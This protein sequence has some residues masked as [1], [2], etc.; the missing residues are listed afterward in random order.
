MDSAMD[1]ARRQDG[2]AETESTRR[3]LESAAISVVAEIYQ[4]ELTV[5]AKDDGPLTKE[6]RL[7]DGTIVSDGRACTMARGIARRAWSNSM[8]QF[9]D[10]ICSL[11]ERSAVALGALQPDLPD[12]VTV[13]TKNK[14]R[15]MKDTAVN[16]ICRTADY[17]A[18]R[19]G[20][21][22][23][24]L[25]DVDTKGMPARVRGKIEAVGGMMAAIISVMPE[26]DVC[27][28]VVR[29]STSTGIYRDDTEE[30]FP[31]SEGLHIYLLVA[32]G[33]DT[34]RFLKVLHARMWLSGY[35]WMVVGKAG[36][37]LERSLIDRMVGGAERLV[38]EAPPR[39]LAPLAQ[40]QSRRIPE[41]REGSPL[42]TRAACPDLSDAE[43]SELSAILHGERRLNGPAAA[44]AREAFIQD[45]AQ[46]LAD[47]S[48]LDLNNARRVIEQQCDG[49]LAPHVVL[50]WD[51]DEFA[52]CTVG[53]ILADPDR[54]I[55][56]TMADPIQGADYGACRATVL[57][58]PSGEIFLHSFAHGETFYRLEHDEA[59]AEI[60]RLSRLTDMAY[61]QQRK[62]AAQTLGISVARLDGVV[63]AERIRRRRAAEAVD[64]NRPPPSGDETTRWPH[65]ITV[66]KDGLYASGGKAGPVW[67]CAPIKVL[68]Y[69]RDSS[70]EA[71][72]LFLAWQ[73]ADGQPHTWALPK[74]LLVTQPGELEAA[75]MDRGLHIDINPD[76]RAMLRDALGG[77]QTSGRVTLISQPGWH[78]PG[79]GDSAF[80]L[81]NGEMIGK[82]TEQLILKSMAENAT[83]KAAIKGTL[84]DW[85]TEIAGRAFGNPVAMFAISAAFA[86]PLLD[87][88]DE[89]SGGFHFFGRSKI[90]KTLLL[91]VAV[92]VW[93]LPRKN[94]LLRDWRSTANAM[95]GAAE[96]CND[97]LLPL[98]E[99]H[100]ADPKDVVNVV[101]SLA[102][103]SGKGRLSR[104]AVSRPR[105]VWRNIVLSTGELDV[106]TMVAKAGQKLPAGA[107]V[108][109]PSIHLDDREVWPCLHDAPTAVA[110]MAELQGALGREY[111]TPIR[112]FLARLAEERNEPKSDIED[113]VAAMRDRFYDLLPP[114]CDPQVRDVARRCALIAAG[115]ELAIAWGILPWERGCAMSGAQIVLGWWLN[116]RGG[117]AASEVTRH[118]EII[119]AFLLEFGASRFVA[120]KKDASTG[121][122]VECSPERV[123]NS[124]AGYR[125]ITG[126]GDEYL[127]APDAWNAL[128]ATQGADPQDV[129]KTLRASGHLDVSRTG[130]NLTKPIGVPDSLGKTRFYVV[131]PS[132]FDPLSDDE[133]P[134]QVV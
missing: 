78:A 73:D 29:R 96:E 131:R 90:G 66:E 3:R 56:V 34:E 8:Q 28:R 97:S 134:P 1:D 41:V 46:Q 105:R 112:P 95:E 61:G 4:V 26:A 113:V 16:F 53:D 108:R 92:S 64:R 44:R 72:A 118:V 130:H 88:L 57:R 80:T 126:A 9:G 40:D 129:A 55:G 91:R 100:Q 21:P 115:G 37:L 75:L 25:I 109:L 30:H 14:L 13:V 133:T 59:G 36:Q 35:G 62:E 89:A 125:R 18:Y 60:N 101:Y 5:L 43:K 120:L 85:R 38:F 22:A 17:I 11:D 132:I 74:R 15:Q 52:G 27:G 98:D 67:L 2:Y 123:I 83:K 39:M 24:A 68:G 87:P 48:G 84:E 76:R 45:N 77:L 110:L 49:V 106:A 32:D 128:C 82:A 122:W 93:G 63:N 79:N 42:D 70:G 33:S 86:G 119:R 107:D 20:Q 58:R 111:G 99:I 7:V 127:I 81:L 47:S 94:G 104:E 6:I 10:L 50:P 117:T 121:S 116:R 12:E 65:G 54:F 102:N 19:D 103:E 69:G 51:D 124:R 23:L 31:G 114:D 71:W